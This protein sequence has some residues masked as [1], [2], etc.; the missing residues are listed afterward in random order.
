MT[1]D[2]L[3]ASGVRAAD[4]EAFERA[5]ELILSPDTAAASRAGALR[6]LVRRFD[7]ERIGSVI[8]AAIRSDD[9]L[10]FRTAVIVALDI[11]Y[12][13]PVEDVEALARRATGSTAMFVA[14]LLGNYRTPLAQRTL[15]YLLHH[16]LPDVRMAAVVSLGKIGDL[17]AIAALR[18]IA[19][20]HLSE[21]GL[22]RAVDEAVKRIQA[23]CAT[24]PAG[25]LAL[26]E[27]Q[28]SEGQVSVL[29]P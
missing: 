25:A 12:R 28:S 23:R 9:P 29:E 4:D 7:R 3:E 21:L 17:A 24:G 19:V 15:M 2:R 8:D 1:F 11:R 14:Y 22:D 20:R 16:G 13:P 6:F 18:R 26:A 27:S 10:L 5:R